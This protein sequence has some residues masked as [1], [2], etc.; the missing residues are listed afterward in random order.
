MNLPISIDFY[1]EEEEEET[2][3]I[4]YLYTVNG[5]KLRVQT[6]INDEQKRLTD[7]IGNFVYENGELSYILFPEGRIT[8]NEQ[9][10]TSNEF[11]KKIILT[12]HKLQ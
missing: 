12:L 1:S 9:L 8:V 6:N 10:E 2:K 3:N 7:Y 5:E 4:S 11:K